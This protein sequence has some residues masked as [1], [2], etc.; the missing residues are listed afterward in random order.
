[1]AAVAK[2][3]TVVYFVSALGLDLLY[4]STDGRWM[5]TTVLASRAGCKQCLHVLQRWDLHRALHDH[6]QPRY[7]M[8]AALLNRSCP[9]ADA[10]TQIP[11]HHFE[12]HSAPHSSHHAA[13]GWVLYGWRHTLLD[14]QE[15]LG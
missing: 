5:L 9:D 8:V 7:G 3:P 14:H 6:H 4:A 1:M 10:L 2:Q 13:G 11:T 12:A 15:Q